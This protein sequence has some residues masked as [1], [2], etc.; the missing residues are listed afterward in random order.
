MGHRPAK[1]RRRK[2]KKQ[3]NR[4]PIGIS[5][6]TAVLMLSLLAAVVASGVLVVWRSHE[7]RQ[8]HQTFEAS[9]QQQDRLLT[10]HSRLLL[11][12]GALSAYYNVEWVAQTELG[13][14]F[15]EK[16]RRLDP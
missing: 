4:P 13:M 8:L 6:R 10:E 2:G 3:A 14:R 15:P 12:R 16:L 7:V 9:R 11:E 1:Q 5:R